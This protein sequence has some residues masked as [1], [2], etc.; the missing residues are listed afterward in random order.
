MEEDRPI[1]QAVNIRNRDVFDVY[2]G[3]AGHGYDG[4]FGNQ[5]TKPGVSRELAC[6]RYAESFYKRLREDAEF[7]AKVLALK[8]KRLGCF[9]IPKQCHVMT[10]VSYLEGID[11][12]QQKDN[13]A[14]MILSQIIRPTPP[15][16]MPF[17]Q[18]EEEDMFDIDVMEDE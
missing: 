2:C 7:A 11:E 10:I 5:H 3:H 1:T 8:G 15:P 9:C 17:P 18:F 13:Y 16:V 4:Y 6:S 12:S 14:K